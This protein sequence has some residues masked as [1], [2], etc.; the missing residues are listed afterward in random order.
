MFYLKFVCMIKR[1]NYI[2]ITLVVLF[3]VFATN[4][5]YVFA[6]SAT[7]WAAKQ[8]EVCSTPSHMMQLYLDFQNEAIEIIWGTEMSTRGLS[9]SLGSWWLFTNGTLWLNKDEKPMGAVE[10]SISSSVE[11]VASTASS[12]VLLMMAASSVV[13]SNLE[14]WTV[15]FRDAPIVRE[16][17]QMLDI[18]SKLF[19]VAYLRSKQIVLTSWLKSP[20]FYNEFNNLIEK[21]Q[22]Q[23]LFEK[24]PKI[25]DTS[26]LSD[27]LL[28]MVSMNAMMRYFIVNI[29]SDWMDVLYNSWHWCFWNLKISDCKRWVAVLKFSDKA[30]YQLTEDYQWL[31]IYWACNLSA[32]NFKNTLNKTFDNNGQLISD[33]FKE[34]GESRKRLVNALVWVGKSIDNR[35]NWKNC[36]D[37]DFSDYELAQLRAYYWPDRSCSSNVVVNGKEFVRDK[38][39]QSSQSESEIT[40]ADKSQPTRKSFK[41][42]VGDGLKKAKQRT[43]DQYR[44]TLENINELL[45]RAKDTG[46]REWQWIRLFWSW[47]VLNVSYS[48]DLYEDF[49]GVYL[50]VFEDFETSQFNAAS[51]DMRFELSQLLWLMDQVDSASEAIWSD[52]DNNWLKKN[53]KDIADYQCSE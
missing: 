5:V 45:K 41:E 40:N 25:K 17:K 39:L 21:Y 35:K 4:F 8:P 53:L 7:G 38:S 48:F 29:D 26:T 1:I 31:W 24:W 28:D 47:V 30:I 36:E 43:D 11:K 13:T 3:Q 37:S 51:A 6:D 50:S 19:Q 20:T 10:S 23:W 14:W 46:E 42:R 32:S 18:Q 12:V 15:L 9:P 22:D 16:Y 34:I 27:I 49:S 44:E 33:S 52:N 2:I